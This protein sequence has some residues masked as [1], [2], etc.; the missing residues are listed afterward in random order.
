MFVELVSVTRTL[1]VVLW[2]PNDFLHEN[3]ICE[4]RKFEHF[5]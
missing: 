1:V 4:L 2:I 3:H 5:K